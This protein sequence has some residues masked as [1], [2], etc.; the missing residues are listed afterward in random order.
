MRRT[1]DEDID[2]I[3]TDLIRKLLVAEVGDRPGRVR[4][5]EHSMGERIFV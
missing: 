2:S 3:G 4:V 1:V 5:S